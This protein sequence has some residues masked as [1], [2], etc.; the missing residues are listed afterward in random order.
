MWKFCTGL[1]RLGIK[2]ESIF[3]EANTLTTKAR[4]MA[5][6]HFY[7]MYPAPAEPC[8]F[9]TKRGF[10]FVQV[11]ND[12]SMTQWLLAQQG[13]ESA[14]LVLGSILVAASLETCFQQTGSSR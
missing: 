2:L 13:E 12:C 5:G 1:T 4:P 7:V 14:A 11:C 10:I 9:L 8:F 3:P 6:K